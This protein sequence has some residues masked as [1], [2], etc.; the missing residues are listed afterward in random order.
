MSEQGKQKKD[1]WDILN[2]LGPALIAA[3]VAVLGIMYNSQQAEI[4]KS[5]EMRQ[6]Y[7]NI[8]A[9]R[10]TSDNSIRATMFEMLFNAMFDKGLDAAER[11][12]EDIHALKKQVM[13]LD[14]LS[15]N[16]DT[17]DIKPLFEDLDRTLSRKIYSPEGYSIQQRGDFFA[18][19]GELR[20]IGRNLSVKQ[21]NALASLS[22][23][24]VTRFVILETGDGE[25]Q[26]M[27]DESA[28]NANGQALPVEIKVSDMADGMLDISLEYRKSKATDPGFK[29]PSFI[30][31]FYDLPYIDNTVLDKDMR[32]GVVL[33]KCVNTSELD[34]FR[35]WLDPKLTRD[36]EELRDSGITQY[37]EIRIIR[38]PAEYIGNRDRPY[39]QDIIHS[40]VEE[41]KGQSTGPGRGGH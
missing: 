3:V 27:K 38:F 17:V 1:L 39:L 8:M 22:G 31:T 4:A 2:A 30:T 18:L 14:L 29:A 34:R 28:S 12:P 41:Q 9:Q 7:T 10:E 32:V 23:S 13:F 5:S 26:V 20:R 33:S 35:N 19:R 21:L 40:L 37:A 25:I 15:R 16:F 11:N 6:V 36:Y 24:A